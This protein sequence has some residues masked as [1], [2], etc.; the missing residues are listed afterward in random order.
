MLDLDTLRDDVSETIKYTKKA[1]TVTYA[2]ELNE[3]LRKY[4]LIDSIDLLLFVVFREK[5]CEYYDFFWDPA[6]YK[7]EEEDLKY[8]QFS[9]ELGDFINITEMENEMEYGRDDRERLARFLNTY[10]HFRVLK[11][12]K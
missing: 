2:K 6:P 5:I 7:E 4:E 1:R 12:V 10:F 8:R 9:E 3:V 11:I